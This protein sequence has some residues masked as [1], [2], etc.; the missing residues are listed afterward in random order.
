MAEDALNALADAI[1]FGDLPPGA[2]LPLGQVAN[3]LGM[4]VSP[5]RDALRGLENLGLTES[6]PYR[7]ARVRELTLSEVNDIHE[8]RLAV[9][10]VSVRRSAER[11]SRDAEVQLRTILA[12]LEDANRG[13]DIRRAVRA[14][15][16]FHMQLA[17]ASD[18]PWATKVLRPLLETAQRYSAA[19]LRSAHRSESIDIESKS[20]NDILDACVLHDADSAAH[21][22][23]R[24]LEAFRRECDIALLAQDSVDGDRD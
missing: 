21:A 22:L 23:H 5:V 16:E 17:A 8:F 7:G 13:A 19:V 4:S 20:H 2:A 12:S 10:T 14:N 9:E 1:I 15:T 24:H 3:S 11:M 6:L 18:S